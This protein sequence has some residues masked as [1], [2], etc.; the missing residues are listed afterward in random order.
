[1]DEVHVWHQFGMP[2]RDVRRWATWYGL[3]YLSFVGF[4][5]AMTGCTTRYGISPGDGEGFALIPMALST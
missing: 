1:M 3:P 4:A 2:S 5:L